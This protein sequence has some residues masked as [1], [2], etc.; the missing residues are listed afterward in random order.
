MKLALAWAY[1]TPVIE[2][3]AILLLGWISMRLLVK[4]LGRSFERAS[5]DPSLARFL[6]KAIKIVGYTVIFACAL[7]ALGVS[8]TGVFAALSGCTIAIGVAL[9][10]SLS[11][12]AGG[13]LL[14]VSP[15]FVTGD[16]IEAGGSEGSVISVD[17]LHTTIQTP[18]SKQISIPN[19]TLMNGHIVNY[20]VAKKR[21]VDIC[22]PVAYDADIE[23]A[24]RVAMETV[25]RHTLA[26]QEPAPPFVRVTSYGDSSVNLTVRAWCATEDYWT[27]QLDLLE[28]IRAAFELNGIFIP[29][30][31]LD[32][33]I[34]DR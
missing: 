17:L 32:V 11:N 1:I 7:T 10:D 18:D 33:H 25:L 30:K 26:L 13:I 4:L 28:Q 24:K 19:G 31:Q 23:A 14:L 29:R 21:R 5:L 15:R 8:T 2:A 20:T 27:L 3:L 34:K 16:Y 22:F 12:V 6:K 9:K